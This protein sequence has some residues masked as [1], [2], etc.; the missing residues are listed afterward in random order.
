MQNKTLTHNIKHQAYSGL[1]ALGFQT[2]FF[3]GGY[4]HTPKTQA[5]HIVKRYNNGSLWSAYKVSN[6]SIGES[7]P[8]FAKRLMLG[9]SISLLL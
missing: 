4:K 9:I 6:T 7:M 2:N 1:R 3:L 8:L 5:F